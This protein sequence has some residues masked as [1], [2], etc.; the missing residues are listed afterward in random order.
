MNTNPSKKKKK[1]N[2]EKVHLTETE[3]CSFIVGHLHTHRS[4]NH[5]REAY[6]MLVPHCLILHAQM[7]T[8][9]GKARASSPVV[10]AVF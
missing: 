7:D 4:S 9:S 5:V 10:L 6:F 2:I 8:T 1:K 3:P